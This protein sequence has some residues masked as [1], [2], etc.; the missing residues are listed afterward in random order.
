MLSFSAVATVATLVAFQ[1][2]VA[3]QVVAKSF[4]CHLYGFTVNKF[5]F[6]VLHS[7]VC[8][9]FIINQSII[10]FPVIRVYIVELSSSLY[11]DNIGIN[12]L[13]EQFLTSLGIG[14]TVHVLAYRLFTAT[15]VAK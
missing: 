1:E 3:I 11:C 10:G 12:S 9:S 5:I 6:R 13:A 7:V 14:L 2:A 8:F 4:L 15:S